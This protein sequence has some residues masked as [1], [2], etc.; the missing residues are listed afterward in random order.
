MIPPWSALGRHLESACRKALYDFQMVE[1]VERLAIALSGGKDSLT[2]LALLCAISGRGLGPWE[3]HA[4]HVS[5]EFS[6]GPGIGLQL[7]EDLCGRL[8]VTLHICSSK[9]KL[10]TLEC[11]SCSRERR[12]LIFTKAQELGCT[13]VAYGHHRD[14]NIATGLMN[15]LGKGEFAGHLPKIHFHAWNMT[16]IRPLIYLEEASIRRFAEQQGFARL[17]CQCPVGQTSRRRQVR[18]LLAQ[19]EAL[20]PD[21]PGNI[22]QAILRDGSQRA[23]RTE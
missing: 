12:R 3:L 14:D 16:V 8:G 5:G 18:D 23:L 13:A 6:C 15:L 2:L 19:I 22:S 17:S 7:L 4:I 20:Y 10:E 11:Y 9:Q 21:A 1:G